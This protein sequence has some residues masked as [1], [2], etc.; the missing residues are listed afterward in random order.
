MDAAL[1]AAMREFWEKGYE[2]TSL[3]DLTAAMGIERPSLYRFFGNKDDLFRRVVER[4]DE[5]HLRFVAHALAAPTVCEVVR[6]FLEGLIET[7]TQSEMPRG[8]LDL[9]AGI[10]CAP[11][12][13]KILAGWRERHEQALTTRFAEAR[14]T[15]DLK[16]SLLPEAAAGYLL[17]VSAGIAIRAKGG[18]TRAVLQQIAHIACIPFR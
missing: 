16:G 12:C 2:G 15:G 1:D 3:S 6:R 14:R 11:G 13:E 17:S 5:C 9:N 4:Y 8:A 18:E 10:A 7:V